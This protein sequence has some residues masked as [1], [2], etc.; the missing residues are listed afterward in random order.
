M[1][2]LS[3]RGSEYKGNYDTDIDFPQ[4]PIPQICADCMAHEG[5]LYTWGNISATVLPIIKC[6]S[7]LYPSYRVTF[8]GHSLGG[9]LSTIG[10][11]LLRN[12]DQTVDLVSLSHG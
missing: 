5:F 2:V 7:T 6:A 12:A 11:T 4:V 9:A 3:F 10:A 8:T 1:I